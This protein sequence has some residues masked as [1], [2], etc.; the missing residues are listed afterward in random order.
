MQP[1]RRLLGYRSKSQDTALDLS[2]RAGLQASRP[3]RRIVAFW[4]DLGHLTRITV[5]RAV[6][7][8]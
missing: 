4:D 6:I 1:R 5:V 7:P 8:V 3:Q 2:P